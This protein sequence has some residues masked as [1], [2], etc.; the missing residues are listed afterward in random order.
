M[1]TQK[2]NASH[3]RDPTGHRKT[4]T[5]NPDVYAIEDKTEQ[6]TYTNTHFIEKSDDIEICK[7]DRKTES[8]DKYENMIRD[9]CHCLIARLWIRYYGKGDDDPES[10]LYKLEH[11]QN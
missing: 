1:N 6:K 9:D 3:I 5:D 7:G 11:I 2:T 10:I 8:D 4:D